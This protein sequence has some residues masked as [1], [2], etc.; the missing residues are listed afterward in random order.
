M[1]TYAYAAS[2]SARLSV[3]SAISPLPVAASVRL[4]EEAD[5][6]LNHSISTGA[7]RCDMDKGNCNGLLELATLYPI[8]RSARLRR[9]G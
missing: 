1:R 8:Y 5:A 3:I 9:L 7:E 4:S 2:S 6:Y